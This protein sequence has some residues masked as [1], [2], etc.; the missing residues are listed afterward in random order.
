MRNSWIYLIVILATASPA[1]AQTSTDNS[2]LAQLTSVR[3]ERQLALTEAS[4]TIQRFFT[5][6]TEGVNGDTDPART[7]RSAA[8]QRNELHPNAIVVFNGIPLNGANAIIGTF[9]GQGPAAQQFANTV[10]DVHTI[11]D[12]EF[13]RRISLVDA[14][15]KLRV[16]VATTFTNTITTPVLPLPPGSF[17]FHAAE[18]FELVEE[19]PGHWLITRVDVQTLSTVPIPDDSFPS[20][21]PVLPSVLRRP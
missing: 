2:S 1:L 17:I 18:D 8:C 15:I 7:A 10:I 9:T 11:V 20:P 21:F 5:C 16:T 12:K 6:I 13:Q 19:E 14:R 3:E 4:Q